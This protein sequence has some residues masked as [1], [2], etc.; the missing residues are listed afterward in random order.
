MR[1]KNYVKPSMVQYELKTENY[2]LQTS[3]LYPFPIGYNGSEDSG[4]N[5]A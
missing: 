1:K 2:L 3:Q 5:L 4:T